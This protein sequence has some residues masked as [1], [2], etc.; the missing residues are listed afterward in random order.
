M[1]VD[2][3]KTGTLPSLFPRPLPPMLPVCQNAN[4]R[5][6]CAWPTCQPRSSRSRSKAR[7]H[8]QSSD[9]WWRARTWLSG[10]LRNFADTPR[11]GVTLLSHPLPRPGCTRLRG[12]HHFDHPLCCTRR[13]RGGCQ[14]ETPFR[15]VC[16][17]TLRRGGPKW[18]PP[19]RRACCTRLQ[20]FGATA[21][22]GCHARA[23]HQ[24]GCQIDTPPLRLHDDQ[25]TGRQTR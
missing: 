10:G 8:R 17:T 1:V 13:R 19:L 9:P 3:R 7:H 14:F 2:Q 25:R 4:A 24:G 15:K 16:D 21:K 18:S 12:V 11:K 6:P 22:P 20:R 5:L 23:L